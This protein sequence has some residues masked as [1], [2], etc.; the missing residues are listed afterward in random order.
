MIEF[1]QYSSPPCKTLVDCKA[2][3]VFTPARYC[4]ACILY[5]HNIGKIGMKRSG[6]SCEIWIEWLTRAWLGRSSIL[7]G[8]L[9]DHVLEPSWTTEKPKRRNRIL[10]PN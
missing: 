1:S 7:D 6:E 5:T 9:E 3:P 10:I 8:A 2:L 4:K